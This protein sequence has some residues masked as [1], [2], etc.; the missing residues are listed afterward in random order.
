VD[1]VNEIKKKV[2]NNLQEECKLLLIR[3][4]FCDV[5][6]YGWNGFPLKPSLIGFLLSFSG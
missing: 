3:K 4:S 6:S 2:D 5:L 1:E